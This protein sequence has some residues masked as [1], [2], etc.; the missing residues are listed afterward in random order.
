VETA[1]QCAFL[2][3]HGCDEIQGYYFSRPVPAKAF[4]EMLRSGKRLARTGARPEAVSP[5][6]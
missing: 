3:K 6:R 4:A 1:E 5:L 2:R